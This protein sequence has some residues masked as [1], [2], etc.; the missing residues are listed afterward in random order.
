MG[1]SFQRK[2]NSGKL[3]GQF[4]IGQYSIRFFFL[5]LIPQKEGTSKMKRKGR[6]PSTLLLQLL[7]SLKQIKKETSSREPW[8]GDSCCHSP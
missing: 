6:E 4:V 2:V 5:P 3:L 1:H 7:P 8:F